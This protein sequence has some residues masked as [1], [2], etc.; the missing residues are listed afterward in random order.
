MI[1]SVMNLL[2]AQ[3]RMSFSI[4]LG[5]QKAEGR[6]QKCSRFTF[7]SISSESRK[8]KAESRSASLCLTFLSIS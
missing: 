8:Q 5:N 2:V 1:V 6:K 4:I 7:L 3:M